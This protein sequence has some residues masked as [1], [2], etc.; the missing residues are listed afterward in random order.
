MRGNETPG[1]IVTNCCTGVGV[2]D[3]ITCAD[4][5]YDCWRGLGVAGGQIL[6]FSTDLLRRPYNTFALPCECVMG[7]GKFQPPQNRYPWTDQQKSRHSWLCPRKDLLCQI[8]YKST[9]WWLLGKWVKYNKNIFMYTFFSQVRVQ[10]RSVD[11]FLHATAQK[12]WNHARMCLLGVW[13]IP[14]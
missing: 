5:Y 6:G 13:I 1:Q 8:W 10:V 2:H 9:H 7:I 12:T 4:L 3:V 11:G 14:P